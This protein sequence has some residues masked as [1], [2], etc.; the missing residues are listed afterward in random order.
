MSVRLTIIFLLFVRL[1]SAQVFS[2]GIDPAMALGG[3]KNNGKM[4]DV[5][6][7]AGFNPGSFEFLLLYE[8]VKKLEFHAYGL[9]ANHVFIKGTFEVAGGMEFIAIERQDN[10]L[11]PAYGFNVEGR[12]VPDWIGL[13]YQVNVRR[14][15]ELKRF[16]LSSFLGIIVKF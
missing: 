3:D 4:W 13:F 9:Q 16:R 12:W 8:E 6:I 15:T 7:R 1:A 11:H 2:T 14:R 10:K 5:H